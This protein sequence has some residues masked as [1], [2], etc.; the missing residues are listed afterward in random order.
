[1]GALLG[2]P[3]RSGHPPCPHCQF[4]QLRPTVL[5]S[6]KMTVSASTNMSALL[7]SVLQHGAHDHPCGRS[8]GGGV[9]IQRQS[10]RGRLFGEEIQGLDELPLSNPASDLALFATCGRRCV[11]H[12]SE[13]VTRHLFEERVVVFQWVEE[14][15]GTG[16]ERG[17]R[18]GKRRCLIRVTVAEKP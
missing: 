11:E 16:A 8:L 7:E 1:M 4:R 15:C 2:A 13:Y 14:F 9:T 12:R 10:S 3:P 6:T 5:T 18:P 17:E